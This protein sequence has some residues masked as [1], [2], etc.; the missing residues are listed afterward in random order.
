MKTLILHCFVTDQPNS[1]NPAA[2]V[3]DSRG[4]KAEKQAL[5]TELDLPVTVFINN[6]NPKLSLLEF[7]YPH[8]EMPMCL[9]GTLGAAQILFAQTKANE[10]EC[11][12][13]SGQQLTLLRSGDQLFQIKVSRQPAP[14][15]SLDDATIMKMLNLE[16]ITCIDQALPTALASVGSPKLLVPIKSLPALLSLKPNFEYIR[17][18]S[19]E[20]KVNGLYVYTPE[21][22]RTLPDQKID[23]RYFH[24]R[25]FNPKGGHNEDAAT[26]VAA[27]ALAAY[28]KAN[29]LIEQGYVM[30]RPSE[31]IVFYKDDHEIWIGGRTG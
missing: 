21:T 30:N 23:T 31:L 8:S 24:A 4:T 10:L 18:W 11:I 9:H 12:T 6:S 7:F 25:A 2:I 26:G 28:L 19:I 16:D 3:S 13:A 1:G 5:A 27:G 17:E 22:Y 14:I 20:N 29:L 15:I